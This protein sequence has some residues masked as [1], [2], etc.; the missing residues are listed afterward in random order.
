M[1]GRVN[2]I[3]T[4]KGLVAD[5]RFSIYFEVRE[6]FQPFAEG[7]CK[8]TDKIGIPVVTGLENSVSE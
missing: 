2:A 5:L 8:G 1:R 4:F 7:L 3:R 6:A